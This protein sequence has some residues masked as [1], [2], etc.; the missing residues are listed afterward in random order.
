MREDD[1]LAWA[2]KAEEDWDIAK[3]ILRRKRPFAG[4]AC[5]LAQQCGEKYMKAILVARGTPFP[6]THDLLILN[7]LC[8][9]DGIFLEMDIDGLDSLSGFAVRTRYPGNEPSLEDAKEALQIAKSIRKFARGWLGLA[10]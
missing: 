10:K 6:K 9:S 4:M 3:S 2:A 8:S 1:P 5:F 7:N